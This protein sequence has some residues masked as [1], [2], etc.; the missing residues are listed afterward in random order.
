MRRLA[1]QT[2]FGQTLLVLL[3]GIA[4]S[5]L[6]GAWIYS[7]ARQEAV[8][9]VG[10]LAAA[11]RIIN[12][13]RL[14]TEAPTSW[15]KRLVEGSSDP[16][17]R[18]TL[19]DN[20]PSI[21][22]DGN[23]EDASAVIA[24]YI[25]QA[26]PDRTVLAAV[27]SSSSDR[28]AGDVMHRG[29]GPHFGPGAGPGPGAYGPMGH[30][31]MMR[32]PLART[33]MSWRGLDTAVQLDD[34]QWMRFATS[35]P[36]TGLTISTR[37]VLAL[38]LVAGTIALLTAWAVRRMTAPLRV[39]SD[40]ALRLGRNVEAPALPAQGTLEMRQAA[41]A[42]NDMQGRL[43]RLVE[44][45][46]L[47]L[48]AIS[49]DLRTQLTLLRLRAE[50]GEEGNERD[51]MLKT[52]AEMEDM[53][54]ATLSF[55]RDEVKT[56]ER[57]RVDVGALVASIANDMADAG[58]PVSLGQVAPAVVIHC[59][60]AALRRAITNLID[61]AVKY[62]GK[63]VVA[64]SSSAA[65]IEITV[66]DEGPGI[67]EDQLAHVLQPF[68]RLESSRNRETGGIG[69]GLAIAASI[70]EAHG[71]KLTL[72]NRPEGGLRARIALPN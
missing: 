39:L 15:R 6:A 8:R 40:A 11:E 67:P 4:L 30:G 22:S 25:R 19:S 20:R 48:A 71:G 36:D 58:L 5:L 38:A 16:T 7:S 49:H 32:G 56:E 31:P 63:S 9:A 29:P 47:M 72:F 35:L 41:A 45:R 70:A 61:N 53:L 44:N 21:A 26:L 46:T 64:L 1:P 51:R 17:F 50:A 13:A 34:S 68:Y 14:V 27:S 12:V 54:A 62:G 42:F 10:A 24:D 66:D 57:K 55:A 28:F 18:V 2:L 23:G 52:I 3:A 60:P 33:A 43:R 69:L 65:G 59:R 37:L